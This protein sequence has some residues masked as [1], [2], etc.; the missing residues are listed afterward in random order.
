MTFIAP[1]WLLVFGAAALVLLL[2]ARRRRSVTVPSVQIWRLI[3]SAG[4]RRPNIRRPPPSL[5]LLLQLLALLIAALALAQPR[6][7][8]APDDH[9]V[10]LLD[11][12]GSMR[13]T[14]LAPT[15]F[16]AARTRLAGMVETLGEA[17]TTRISV[18]VA[19]AEPAFA[20][21]RQIEAG[22][23]LPLLSGL[24][25]R[26]GAADWAAAARLIP[27]VAR[28]GETIRVVALTDD[29][30]AT[31]AI[32]AALPGMAVE[33][34]P[35][36]TP[37]PNRA[38]TAIV[39]PI[40]AI[41]GVWSVAGTVHQFGEAEAVPVDIAVLFRRAGDDAYLDF[42]TI[43][44]TPSEAPVAATDDAMPPTRTDFAAELRFPGPGSLI[45]RLPPDIAPQDDATY[46]VLQP[47][48]PARVLLI[49]NA[50]PD[51][52]R[53]LGA[54]GVALSQADTLPADRGAAFDLV[55]VSDVAVD[56]QPATSVLWLERGR[57][58][59]E[60]E[61]VPLA[62]AY[63]IAWDRAHPLSAEIDW[64]DVAVPRAFALPARDDATVIVA[65]EDGPIIDARTTAAGRDVRVALGIDAS[66]WGEAASLPLFIANLIDW[67]AVPAGGGAGCLVDAPCR[68][69]AGFT[70]AGIAA[71]DFTPAAGPAA[72]TF[73]PETAGFHLFT[74][75]G[76][77][78]EVAVN[79]DGVTESIPPET[80]AGVA[81]APPTAFWWR[82]LLGLALAVLA[83]EALVAGRGAERFFRRG[84]LRGRDG[85][86]RRRRF[87]LVLRGLALAALVAA[88]VPAPFPARAPTE[89]I[90]V[91]DAT[92][93][94]AGGIPEGPGRVVA[95]NP[96]FLQRDIDGVDETSAGLRSPAGID[97]EGALRLAAAQ[98]PADIAGR[99]VVTGNGVATTG[100]AMAAIPEL[101]ERGIPVDILT[102]PAMAPGE[103][104]VT[105]VE[106]PQALFAGDRFTLNAFIASAA[107]G[108]AT[109]TILRDGE[110]VS[111]LTVDLIPGSNRIEVAFEPV[112]AGEH[113]FEVAV[114]KPGDVTEAN[115]RDG[116]LVTVRAAPTVMVVAPDAEW[117]E[118]FAGALR[119]QG[120]DA[121]VV[122]PNR[123]PHRMG[124]WLD[125]DLVV[126][127]NLPA[128][129]LTT[130]Q[131]ALLADLVEVHGRGLLILGG[132]SAFGPGGYFQTD[133]ERIS[134][135]SSRVPQ[136]APG[137]AIVFVL[138]RSGSM[139]APVG[140]TNRLAIAKEATIAA[141]ELLH[142]ETQVGVVVFDSEA[143]RILP[144][145]RKNEAALEAALA[146]LQ[147][148]GGTELYPGIADAVEQLLTTDAQAKHI[149]VMT[150]GLL[151]P[152]DFAPIIAEATAGGITISAVAIGSAADFQRASLIARL[153]GGAFHATQ[154]FRALPSILSQEAMMLSRSP[155]EVRE[156]PVFWLDRSAPFLAG[157]P[158]ALPPLDAY[159]VTT[160]RAGATLH[161]GAQ[162]E[163]GELVPI[164]ASWRYGNGE[165]AAFASHGAGIG[166]QRWLGMAEY[167]LFWGQIARHLV[168]V[169]PGVGLWADAARHGDAV[170]IELAALD[171]AGLPLAD[172][173]P[174]IELPAGVTATPFR[175]LEPGRYETTVMRPAAGRLDATVRLEDFSVATPTWFGYPAA[176][177]FTSARPDDLARI[178]AATGGQRVTALP[179]APAL[180]WTLA[181]IWRPWIAIALAFFLADL[182]VRY[183]A[184]RSLGRRSAAPVTERAPDPA[185]WLGSSAA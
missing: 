2:H 72:G 163:E 21:A 140:D 154:D 88:L 150:D 142:P 59:S 16:D 31:A 36:G 130:A 61:P 86:A 115:N 173:A 111:A 56:R 124:L 24:A 96:A 79:R 99:I 27:A 105:A 157:L 121:S 164:L 136:D 9:V 109:V 85:S 178:A 33:A 95:D 117:G 127:M 76:R 182:W 160:A 89:A 43:A 40:D 181:P 46:F 97:L 13:T 183:G 32:A 137:A 82:V 156:T 167:P 91:V 106:P 71:P 139:I 165:V 41:A 22:G 107:A 123:T 75:H 23:I 148:G 125:Y 66:R 28:D 47:A 90:V 65:A 133:L 6:F 126:L 120:F 68:F 100:D 98:L 153:G 29:D 3:E 135:L 174:V 168:Q 93:P 143:H 113:L 37:V 64:S 159:V 25:P 108:P 128:I 63:F 101:G 1:A 54:A 42:G 51:L 57:L 132:E 141:M 175:E 12:S 81:Y 102:V 119:I 152:R 94:T 166:S 118:V 48:T 69:P 35:F 145:Q 10:F 92:A 172:A 185:P 179:A 147:P 104:L 116:A 14:D 122:A 155:L 161:L 177:D 146:P 5:P 7:G 176:L 17:G 144:L 170:T 129:D 110:A 114:T 138:D 34:V 11:A 30:A 58:A 171:V 60:P 180:E 44:V 103:V 158:A 53:A 80:P 62:D 134:P 87:Q 184:I 8:A 19:S 169:R 70:L 151:G 67:L 55:I 77:T 112:S 39:T 49:G 26:D 84:A 149:V 50:R 162:D 45:L 4:S 52:V 20:V 74:G 83:I 78:I 73:L 15:R 18:I 38:L 131:Q